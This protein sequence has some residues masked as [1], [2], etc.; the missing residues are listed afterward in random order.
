MF[1]A[2]LLLFFASATTAIQNNHISSQLAK[3]SSRIA[4][5][6][7]PRTVGNRKSLKEISSRKEKPSYHIGGIIQNSYEDRRKVLNHCSKTEQIFLFYMAIV[8]HDLNLVLDLLSLQGIFQERKIEEIFLQMLNSKSAKDKVFKKV[9]FVK[10]IEDKRINLDTKNIVYQLVNDED[11]LSLIEYSANPVDVELSIN[12]MEQFVNILGQKVD[13]PLSDMF[14]DNFIKV[15]KM[16]GTLR[17]A[18]ET[19]NKEDLIQ[20]L[21]EFRELRISKN[22]DVAVS[23]LTQAIKKLDDEELNLFHDMLQSEE[24]LSVIRTGKYDLIRFFPSILSSLHAQK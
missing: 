16:D 17:R 23:L 11:K 2:L 5:P 8:N 24:V 3:P 18:K 20:A 6:R 7:P 1:S 12:F 10:M 4:S 21:T 9:L 13:K 22:T 15:R 19:N 14:K